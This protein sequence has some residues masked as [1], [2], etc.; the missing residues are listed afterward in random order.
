MLYFQLSL[1]LV[2]I[3]KPVGGTASF[4]TTVFV[5]ENAAVGT[6]VAHHST[7]MQV[8]STTYRLLDGNDYERF[9]LT[10]NQDAVKV[11]NP[12]DCRIQSIYQLQILI[13]NERNFTEN[14]TLW[15]LTV[16]VWTCLDTLHTTTKRVKS[17]KDP[18]VYPDC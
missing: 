16:H 8:A 3:S 15:N 5:P 9:S 2:S 1:V 12:L 11:A 7:S 13:G 17:L 14:T 18:L 4:N 10:E 6:V